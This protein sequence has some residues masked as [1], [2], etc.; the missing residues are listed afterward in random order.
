MGKDWEVKA[1]N[2]HTA[3]NTAWKA[4]TLGQAGDIA[5]DYTVKNKT[6]GEERHV[7]ASDADS[8]GCAIAGGDFSDRRDETSDSAPAKSTRP[9]Q[10]FGASWSSSRTTETWID[11]LFIPIYP[12]AWCVGIVVCFG[13]LGPIVV[14]ILGEAGRPYAIPL[15]AIGQLVCIVGAHVA[16]T[17][18]K[19]AL[20]R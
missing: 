3:A 7:L 9:D 11:W 16:T 17:A 10:A 19:N 2:P 5:V 13:V 15:T 20:K 4:V 1:R 18:L 8:L 12:I 6:S 14:A